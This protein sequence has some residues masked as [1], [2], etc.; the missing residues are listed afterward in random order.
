M[1][2][3]GLDRLAAVCTAIET[4]RRGGTVSLSG[5]YGG[6][7]DPMPMMSLFDKQIQLHMVRPPMPPGNFAD[8]DL[9]YSR[10]EVSGE[11][12]DEPVSS[13]SEDSSTVDTAKGEA[14]D[15]K[16]TVADAASGVKD[17][18]ARSRTWP[19]RLS[20]KPGIW[21]TRRG[22]SCGTRRVTSSRSS[23]RG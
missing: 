8:S 7:A 11:R 19:V 17:G 22:P 18:G 9:E 4:V 20:I 1:K 13:G 23:H 12:Y 3:A 15:V 21:W 5:I 6:M 10:T 16:D 2:K 14:A